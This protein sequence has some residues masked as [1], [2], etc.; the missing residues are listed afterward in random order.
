MGSDDI[1]EVL[2]VESETAED[3]AALGLLGG[4][5]GKIKAG[6]EML[7][8]RLTVRDF[9]VLGFLLDQKFSS[10][11]QIYFR[12]FD[13][14]KKGS[15]P[16]PKNLHVT[17]QRLAILRRAGFIITERVY[18]EP[19][20]LYLLSGLGFQAFQG[21]FPHDAYAMPMRAVDFRNYEHDTKVNDCRIAIEKTGRVVKWFSER[22]LRMQGFESKF[23]YQ[24]LPEKIVPDGLF[25]SSKGERVAFEIETSPRKKVRYEEKRDAYRSVMKG[26]KPLLHMVFWVG[27][28]SRIMADL[29]AVAGKHEEFRLESYDHFLSKL[30]PRGVPER[31]V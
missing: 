6:S 3:V 24:K 9:G 29:R 10:L 13:T 31:I 17:R 25:I 8:F 28:T 14:R 15:D 12:F 23:S 22:R 7:N 20:S 30:W 2:E 26:E 18:S 5:R 1:E 11:E 4:D 19:K 27:A 16:L 21:K